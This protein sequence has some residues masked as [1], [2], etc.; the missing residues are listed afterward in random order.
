[1]DLFLTWYQQV[2]IRLWPCF[3]ALNLTFDLL[4]TLDVTESN[5]KTEVCDVEKVEGT[6]ANIEMESTEVRIPSETI[7]TSSTEEELG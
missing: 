2:I 1:M 7:R 3:R 6:E 5:E 4:Y